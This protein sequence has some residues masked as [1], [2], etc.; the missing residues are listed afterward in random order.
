M[1]IAYWIKNSVEVEEDI[2]VDI[3]ILLEEIAEEDI[4]SGDIAELLIYNDEVNTFDWVIRCLMEILKYPAAQAEQLTMLIHFKGKAT[5]KTAP[6]SELRPIKE[7]L[8][9]R[10]LSAVIEGGSED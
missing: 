9:D 5:V 2:D 1:R 3:D 8:I 10:G 6:R 4:G 7:A